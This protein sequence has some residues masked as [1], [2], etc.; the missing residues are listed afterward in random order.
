MYKIKTNNKNKLV[1][2]GRF[3]EETIHL[4]HCSETIEGLKEDSATSFIVA[5]E[6]TNFARVHLVTDFSEDEALQQVDE[7]LREKEG[8]DDTHLIGVFEAQLN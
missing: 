6:C 1:A 5:E 8:V 4:I 7:Y 2:I 3:G